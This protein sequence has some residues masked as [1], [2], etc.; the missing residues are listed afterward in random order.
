MSAELAQ[1][2]AYWLRRLGGAVTGGVS[3]LGY[4]SRFLV[5]VL[6]HSPQ[7]F[8]RMHLTCGRSTSRGCS[9]W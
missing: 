8:R 7:A 6:W 2:L 1:G 4:V 9:R 5:A 3:K